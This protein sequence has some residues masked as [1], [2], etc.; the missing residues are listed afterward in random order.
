MKLPPASLGFVQSAP[1]SLLQVAPSLKSGD[2][3]LSFLTSIGAARAVEPRPTT[4][5]A[6]S[7]DRFKVFLMVSL[8]V[9]VWGL[10]CVKRNSDGLD[11]RE[12]QGEPSEKR[13][14]I[15]CVKHFPSRTVASCEFC[16]GDYH[17]NKTE[18]NPR[19]GGCMPLRF[20]GLCVLRTVSF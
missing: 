13:T 14:Y 9:S 2:S 4:A 1:K 16:G 20:N 17:T 6:A 15:L 12:G 5:R 8:I 3:K 10:G 7:Q 19:S 18:R 11:G